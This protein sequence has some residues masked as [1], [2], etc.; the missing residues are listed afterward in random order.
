MAHKLPLQLVIHDG[1]LVAGRDSLYLRKQWGPLPVAQFRQAVLLLG[2]KC[3]FRTTIHQVPDLCFAP[4]HNYC[5]NLV[6][7]EAN[8]HDYPEQDETT[9]IALHQK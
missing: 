4:K 6:D 2:L 3:A 9:R 7:L 1:Q 8:C 5:I